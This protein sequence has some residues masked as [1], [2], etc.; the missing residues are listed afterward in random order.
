LQEEGAVSV[1]VFTI[2]PY[3]WVIIAVVAL[4]FLVRRYERG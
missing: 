1:P 4:W 3:L 2:I